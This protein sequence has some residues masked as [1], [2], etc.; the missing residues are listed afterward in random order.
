MARQQ[1]SSKRTARF[2]RDSNPSTPQM[3]A[4]QALPILYIHYSHWFAVPIF[5]K[6]M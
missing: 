4:R 2:E 3:G 5:M 6:K 1:A